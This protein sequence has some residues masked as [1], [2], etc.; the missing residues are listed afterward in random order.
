MIGN[1]IQHDHPVRDEVDLVELWNVLWKSKLTVICITLAFSIAS[2][3]YAFTQTEIYRSEALL[4]PADSKQSTNSL[5]SQFGS[6]AEFVGVSVPNQKGERIVMAIAMMNSREFLRNF[7]VRH[8]LLVPLFANSWSSAEGRAVINP[9]IF[10]ETTQSWVGEKP[11]EGDAIERFR[12]ILSITQN[13]DTSLITVAINW[14]DPTLAQQWL[15]WLIA[16]INKLIKQQDLEEANNAIEYLSEQ[17]NTTQLVEMQRVFYQL[18][19]SQMQIAM[20]A[21]ARE[22]Y[23]L[24]VIDPAYVPEE[25]VSPNKGVVVI[26]G[27]LLGLLLSILLVILNEAK[28]RRKGSAVN[29]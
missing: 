8:D 20:L 10:N 4:A 1:N 22:D 3:F 19:E 6:A 2:I 12:R 16:D 25:Y 21:D 26:T 14:F 9:S 7:I 5:L 29:L 24:K 11:S 28:T 13:T 15:S 23:V 18:I 17:L 27:T